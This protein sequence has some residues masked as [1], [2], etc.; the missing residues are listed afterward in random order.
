MAE[1]NKKVEMGMIKMMFGKPHPP[2]QE[3]SSL[4]PF[5]H[6]CP[7]S[8]GNSSRFQQRP[9]RHCRRKREHREQELFLQYATTTTF[10]NI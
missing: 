3:L 2:F 8:S 1:E 6:N 9:Y 5:H 10:S 4:K 7:F